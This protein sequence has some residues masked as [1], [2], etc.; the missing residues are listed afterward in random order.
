MGIVHSS[1]ASDGGGA[2]CPVDHGSPPSPALPVAAPASG[3]C[4]IDHSKGGPPAGAGGAVRARGTAYNVYAQPLDPSNQMPAVAA[5][6]PSPGQRLPLSTTRVQASIR[7]GGTEGTWTYPSP[8][9]FWNA[10]VRKGK[11]DGVDET[12]MD[13]VVSIHNEMNERAWA[14]LVRWE[15]L[16]VG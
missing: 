3:A 16:H 12:D 8:Q 1:G 13:S 5:Q 2:K 4:P 6:A 14:Q 9:M 10:L 15:G 11:A 7:K